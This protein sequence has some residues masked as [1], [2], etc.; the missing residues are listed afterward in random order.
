MFDLVKKQHDGWD[1]VE[2]SITEQYPMTKEEKE[3]PKAPERKMVEILIDD[4]SCRITQ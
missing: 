2:L 1:V 4:M 3:S